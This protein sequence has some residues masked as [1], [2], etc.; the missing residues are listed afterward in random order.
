MFYLVPEKDVILGITVVGKQPE[1][2]EDVD[3][4]HRWA[5]ASFVW[6]QGK[7]GSMLIK[8]GETAYLGRLA[9]YSM[10]C[11]NDKK[12]LEVADKYLELAYNT[13]YWGL[14]NY[15]GFQPL[16]GEAHVQSIDEAD[17][18][19]IPP[20]RKRSGLTTYELLQM[21]KDRDYKL[22]PEDKKLFEE[23]LK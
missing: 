10:E 6:Y 17:M 18:T 11:L 1:R 14:R 12:L 9:A 21:D 22:S 16:Q 23:Y 13:K 4:M 8:H 7:I 19:L 2:W 3:L 15:Q 20:D 5:D